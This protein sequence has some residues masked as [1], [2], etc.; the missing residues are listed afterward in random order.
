LSNLNRVGKHYYDNGV[1]VTHP[2]RKETEDRSSN[3]SPTSPVILSADH[4]H[5]D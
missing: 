3:D 5:L 2:E 1:A 4:E